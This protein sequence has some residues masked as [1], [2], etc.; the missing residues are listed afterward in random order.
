V[1]I[2]IPRRGALGLAAALAA[3][4][5]LGAGSTAALGSAPIAE[6]VWAW[7]NNS[8]GQLGDVSITASSVPVHVQ[9]LSGGAI[10]LAVGQGHS[11]AVLA[12][13]T[14]WGWGDDTFGQLGD[15]NTGDNRYAP[16]QAEGLDGVT[17]VAAGSS[18][19]LALRSDGT[20][21]AWGSNSSGQLGDGTETDSAVPEQVP[22]LSN[23]IAIAAGG[24]HSLAVRSDGS[25][26]A[27]GDNGSG[28]LGDGTTNE[29][30]SPTQVPGLYGIVAIAGGEHH[31]LAVQSDGTVWAWGL[32]ATGQ[33]GNGSTDDSSSP[34]Q[35]PGLSGAV[36]VAAG[37][38]HSLAL[39]SDGTVWAWGDNGSGQIG[40]NSATERDVPTQVVGLA[41]VVEIAAG[42]IN[43]LALGSDGTVWAWGDDT[44]GEL[45]DGGTGLAEVP[46]PVLV[47]GHGGELLATGSEAFHSLL[48]QPSLQASRPSVA[49]PPATPGSPG[50]SRVV[51]LS[52][53][54]MVGVHVSAVAIAGA[55]PDADEF[56]VSDDGCSGRTVPSGGSCAVG[57][58][59]AP[60]A[61]GP[62]VATLRISS[63]TAAGATSVP[64]SG[65]G[66]SSSPPQFSVTPAPVFGTG[67]N[68]AGQLGTGGTVNAST[69]RPMAPGSG[70]FVAAATGSGHSLGLRADG[71]VS[72]WGVN[73]V[74]QLGEG[75]DID[76]HK[77]EQVLGGMVAVAAGATHSM[78]LS[79]DGTVWTWGDNAKGQLGD[80]STV[81]SSN[82]PGAV[83][84][85][86]RVVA[87]AAGGK[88][89]LALR[90][91]GTVW[92]WGWNAS[93]QLGNNTT[94]DS[95]L[96]VEVVGLSGVVAIAAGENHSLALR[97]DGTVWAWGYN[98][99]GELG[100]N[101][102]TS[103]E[104]PVQVLGLHAVAIAA[105]DFHNLALK[106]DGTVWAWGSG[107]YGQLG[108][109][110]SASHHVPVQVPGITGVVQIAAGV[111]HSLALDGSGR[112]WAWGR[113]SV[114]QL[115]IGTT[116]LKQL[117]PAQMTTL[118]HGGQALATGPEASHTL[119][120]TQPHVSLSLGTLH[121]DPETV[122]TPSGSLTETVTND[123]VVPL[124]FGQ[125]KIVG[126]DGDEFTVTGDA[127]SGT[128]VAPG[129]TCVIGVRFKPVVDG[130]PTATLRIVSNSPTSP[131]LVTLDPPAAAVVCKVAATKAG[132]VELRYALARQVR[133]GRQWLLTVRLRRANRTLAEATLTVAKRS[134]T[135]VLQ[136]PQGLKAGVY[137][138]ESTT[139]HPRTRS[140]Q[141][142]RLPAVRS[143]HS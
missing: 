125:A 139:R 32:N 112:A 51:T 121:F 39:R 143:A 62:A 103:S 108:G 74:G 38:N 99:E 81:S 64:L 133:S 57:V 115:G 45:G 96:P 60:V 92:A 30:D 28:Q 85:L 65:S 86:S 18:H 21:W 10:A 35:V 93:G 100:N 89:S 24:L 22:V 25:V 138:L 11:L 23:V 33:L 40:D 116:S 119:V 137:T 120:I 8:N 127:C 131:D 107:A 27:W 124:V 15:G 53:P 87:I 83:E 73:G 101:T 76:S 82:L 16:V 106:A 3:F 123:G 34:T 135:V 44:F 109:G 79:S 97:S 70:A 37:E 42:F 48:A 68:S 102:T 132:V 13:G 41:D 69:P 14:V 50:G 117:A 58:R 59:F 9:Y 31:T 136:V 141:Q 142:I 54:G 66:L 111:A 80:G 122:G 7:G 88:H 75:T 130:T 94:Y 6:P 5:L 84:G 110:S 36:S 12:D 90:S 47:S 52:N 4:T 71:T 129:H 46:V 49:F 126:S 113:N 72:A 98:G 26:W 29:R 91:D 134:G 140:V 105:G 17:A 56:K 118:G 67:S 43:S 114:G 104:T 20:V 19:S 63:D 95:N 61:V 1:H 2:D 78:A 77:P 55:G 128:T